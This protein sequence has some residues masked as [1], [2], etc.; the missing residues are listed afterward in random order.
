[1]SVSV[2]RNLLSSEQVLFLSLLVPSCKY[3]DSLNNTDCWKAP[4]T[5]SDTYELMDLKGFLKRVERIERNHLSHTGMVY[6]GAVGNLNRPNS[7]ST[8]IELIYQTCNG[9]NFLS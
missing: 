9:V 4:Q 8:Q 5:D 3:L 7:S 1:M 2:N 6:N